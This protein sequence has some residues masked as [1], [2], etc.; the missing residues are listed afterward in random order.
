MDSE[1]KR[2]REREKASRADS[3]GAADGETNN[4]ATTE[5][6]DQLF[7]R[8]LKHENKYTQEINTFEGIGHR[9]IDAYG[10]ESILLLF[11]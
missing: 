11:C 9:R 2:G 7:L 6:N 4:H 5:T 10:L 8:M 1:G 3:N